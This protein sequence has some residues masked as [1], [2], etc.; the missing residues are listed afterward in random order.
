MISVRAATDLFLFS[1]FS[2]YWRMLTYQ[3]PESSKPHP[4]KHVLLTGLLLSTSIIN[5]Q[6]SPSPE[7]TADAMEAAVT[8]DLA[9][10]NAHFNGI[11]SFRIDKRDRLVADYTNGGP[12]YR[13]DIAY[14]DFLDASTIAFNEDEKTLML[15][16]QDPRSKCIDKEVKKSGAVS[17]TGRMNLPLPANDPKGEKARELM[18]RFVQNKQDMQLSRLAETNTRGDRKK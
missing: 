1:I 6:N 5:A 14:F 17:P 8:N 11:A 13:T 16:C 3:P 12:V 9:Q 4:M 10:L 18:S 7:L 2:N 15:Q